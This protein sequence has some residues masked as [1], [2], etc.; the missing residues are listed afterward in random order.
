MAVY[1]SAGVW[2]EWMT[3]LRESGYQGTLY[4]YSA[5]N[6]GG[7]FSVPYF[8]MVYRTSHDDMASDLTT[9]LR[10]AQ[11]QE[12]TT[13]TS[14]A[15][16]VL[17]GHS[18]GGGLAQYCLANYPSDQVDVYWNW[19]KHDPWFFVRSLFHLQHPTSPLSSTSLVH[20][21]FFGH[22]CPRSHVSEFMRWMPACESMGWPTGMMGSLGEWWRGSS[23]WLDLDQVVRNITGNRNSLSSDR[24]CIMLGSEDVLMDIRM[25]H[26]QAAE[27]RASFGQK[28]EV[29]NLEKLSEQERTI[30]PHIEGVQVESV[31]ATRLVVV[32]SAGHHLQN[33]VQSEAAAKAFLQFVQQC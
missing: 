3:Y 6:H 33:D 21:A 12:A 26:R 25:C 11:N 16:V 18:S 7:S 1:G 23:S 30:P 20:G 14:D 15:N 19:A 8:R 29:E 5:R 24:V 13:Q 9:C 2:L 22:E 27:Y 4:A 17:V 28:Q 10:H 31:A 32:E